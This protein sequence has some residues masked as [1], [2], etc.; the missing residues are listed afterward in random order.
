MNPNRISMLAN[1]QIKSEKPVQQKF[2]GLDHLRALA[3]LLVFLFHYIILSGGMPEWLPYLATFGWTGVDL[4]FVLSGFLISSQLFAQIK[5]GKKIG[6]KQFFL[7]RFFRIVPA[8]LVTLGLY[9]CFPFFR[10]KE[11]LPPLWK[12]LTFTQNIGLNLKDFGTFSHAWSLCVEE[13]F[14]FFLPITLVLLQTTQS[15]KRSYWV[16]IALFVAGFLV[17]LYCFIELYVPKKEYSNSWIYWYE[18]IYYPTYTRLDGLLVG[19]SIAG[20]YQFLPRLWDKI[21]RY[22]NLFI[23]L[24]LAVLVAAF[25]LC[26]EPMGFNASIFGFSLIAI[27]Y[28]LMVVGAVSPTSFLYRWNS[29]ITRWLAT[30]SYAIYLSH[31]AVIHMTHHLLSGFSLDANLILLVSMVTCIAFAILL[32]IFVE[33]PFMR[34]RAGIMEHI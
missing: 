22:G 28:G 29:K 30:L 25:F 9:F 7:K 21:A 10:E 20:V 6:L 11:S 3:I 31:K 12:F 26:E 5:R 19:I 16:L 1:R 14:Y 33:K 34:L 4:F 15:L 17:R 2:F 24:S 23:V 27:G 18:Y 13:H 32:H 8:Y